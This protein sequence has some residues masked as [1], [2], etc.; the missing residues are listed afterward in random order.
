[1]VG[2]NNLKIKIF[3]DGA[4]IDGMRALRE[5]QHVKGF[6][7]NPSLMRAAGV[8]SYAEFAKEVLSVITDHPV[9][10]EVFA[11]DL[12]SIE[13]Q[14]REI[15]RWG[16]N[17]NVKIPVTNTKG[18]Y[19]TPVIRKLSESG[20]EVN[21][22]AVF[23]LAQ[24]EAV[25]ESLDNNTPAIISVFAGRIADTGVDP[26]PLMAAA[27][28]IMSTKPKSELLWASSRE[29]LNI[30]HA[31]DSGADIITVTHE[32]LGKLL[33]L[34]KDLNQYS[35]ETVQSFFKDATASGY[36]IETGNEVA[37]SV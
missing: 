2:L 22:T 31:E 5:N 24:V 15:G 36:T 14:A 37:V 7:T 27:K 13:A 16:E 12:P 32:M 34:N 6:T 1:M 4:Q 10:F 33:L 28:K 21:V 25:T 29:I 17:V 35:L 30:F 23:T 18:E 8:E 3:A 20:I 26:V 19:T 11:D 9:S